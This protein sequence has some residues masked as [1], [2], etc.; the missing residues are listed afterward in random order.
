[1][2]FPEV[3]ANAK[4]ARKW[5]WIGLAAFAALQ[6]YLVQELLAAMLLFSLIFVVVAIA[7]LVIYLFDRA[8]QRTMEWAEPQTV[9]A[10]HAARKALDRA[11]EFSKKQL[12]RQRSQPVR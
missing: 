10:A 9:R 5:L 3:K 6:V 12:H 11:E 4:K 1:M 7:A 2:T 8:G